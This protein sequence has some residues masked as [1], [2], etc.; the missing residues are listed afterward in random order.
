VLAEALRCSPCKG[1]LV[2]PFEKDVPW[3]FTA[4][5][6]FVVRW[7]SA[8]VIAGGMVLMDQRKQ[9]WMG[10]RPSEK[11]CTG[12]KGVLPNLFRHDATSWMDLVHQ[13]DARTRGPVSGCPVVVMVE[14][15]H[16]RNGNHFAPCVMRGKS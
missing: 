9:A 8:I 1:Y 5:L 2:H 10:S 13:L 12:C 14:S 11:P 6:F 7:H 15:T 3:A 4:R 16:D